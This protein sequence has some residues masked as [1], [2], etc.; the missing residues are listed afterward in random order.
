MLDTKL[1]SLCF[2]WKYTSRFFESVL[3]TEQDFSTTSYFS[4]SS[5]KPSIFGIVNFI[6]SIVTSFASLFSLPSTSTVTFLDA[7]SRFLSCAS[8]A[9]VIFLKPVISN[10]FAFDT[11]PLFL[12]FS[13]IVTLIL[14]LS[15]LSTFGFIE[16][17]NKF[18]SIVEDSETLM[19][20]AVIVL[21]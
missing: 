21:S 13:L 4:G 20:L 14:V 3:L 7:F 5:I 17:S 2:N 1:V 9:G 11:T 8:S 10:S 15:S 16:N 12:C 19:S 6:S 18:L